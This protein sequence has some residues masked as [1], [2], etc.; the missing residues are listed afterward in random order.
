MLLILTLLTYAGISQTAYDSTLLPNS[1]LRKAINIIE[2]CK[3]VKK[4]LALE[5]QKTKLLDSVIVSKDSTIAAYKKMEA[6]SEKIETFYKSAV[7]NLN[8]TIAN[9]ELKYTLQGGLYDI[10]KKK[11]WLFLAAGLLAGFIIAK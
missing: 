4:E 11:K 1:Q 5:K 7:N 10:E 8:M 3:V 9:Q 2:E 6:A